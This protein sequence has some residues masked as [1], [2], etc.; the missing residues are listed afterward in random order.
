MTLSLWRPHGRL[1]SRHKHVVETFRTVLDTRSLSSLIY[2]SPYDSHIV[3]LFLWL[4]GLKTRNHYHIN[5][6]GY[7]FKSTRQLLGCKAP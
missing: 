7:K 5:R 2:G 6:P 3:D 4:K 1:F